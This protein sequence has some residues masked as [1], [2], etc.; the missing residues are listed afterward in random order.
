[1]RTSTTVLAVLGLAAGLTAVAAAPS[2]A[3]AE[4]GTAGCHLVLPASH[5]ADGSGTSRTSRVEVDNPASVTLASACS[6]A[7][8]S[9][10]DILSIQATG[11][12]GAGGFMAQN[13]SNNNCQ[14]DATLDPVNVTGL[15]KSG[16]YVVTIHTGKDWNCTGPSSN[17]DIYLIVKP[18][19]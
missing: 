19:A 9:V 17:P 14:G 6:G 18:R 10:D 5:Q 15:F 8:L 2:S 4:P 16:T 12:D 1:M 7:P 3:A 13:F 11:H